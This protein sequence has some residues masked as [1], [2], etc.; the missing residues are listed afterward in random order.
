MIDF[1]RPEFERKLADGGDRNKKPVY[2]YVRTRTKTRQAVGPLKDEGGAAVSDP[3]K[4][5]DLLNVTFGK[6]FT[7]EDVTTIPEP[8][9]QHEGE[10]LGKVK[11]TVRDVK[12]KIKKLRREAAAGPDGIGPGVL[13]ELRDE[14]AHFEG[15]Y[16]YR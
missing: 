7:R 3:R 16:Y 11:V 9:V 15:D 6:A 4:M 13:I 10:E 14:I 2:A 12:I 8:D 1:W 5:A